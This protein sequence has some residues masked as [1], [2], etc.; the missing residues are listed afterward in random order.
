MDLSRLSVVVPTYNMSEYLDVLWKDMARTGMFDRVCEVIFVDDGSTD[1]TVARLE[2]LAADQ[3]HAGQIRVVRQPTNLGRFAARLRGAEVAKG[4]KILFL[5]TRLTLRESFLDGVAKALAEAEC[6]VGWVDIDISRNVFC[7]YWERSHRIIFRNNFRHEHEAFEINKEN[8]DRYVKG[9]TVFLVDR[10][11]FLG[12][13]E[14]FPDGLLNDDTFLMK[15]IV[16]KVPITIHPSVR[17]GWVPRENWRDFLARLWERGPSFAEYHVFESRGTFFWLMCLAIAVI[18][19]TGV[20]LFTRPALGMAIVATGTIGV[21]LST[22][23]FARS[24]GEFFRLVVLHTAVTFTFV[25]AAM[26]GIG[27]QLLS[28]RRCADS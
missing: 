4:S 22:G 16:E 12:A 19:V 5:D 6:I 20:L 14:E 27:V 13:C 3:Q 10:D 1:G 11:L 9:T 23:I 18:G 7:L 21:A 2:S 15:R 24:V 8:F 25:F 17:V 28:R 26:R